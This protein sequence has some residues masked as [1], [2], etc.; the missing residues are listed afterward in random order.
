MQKII[1]DTN[2][3][4]SSLIQ[5]GYSFRI[6]NDLFFEDKFQLCVSDELIKEYYDVLSRPKFAKFQDFFSRAEKL[7]I[8]IE[9]KGIHFIPTIKLNLI[10]DVDDNKILELADKCLADFII[11][12]NTN[13][14]NFTTYKLT[15]IVTPKEY[16]ENYQPS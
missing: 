12:G 3:I 7:L 2:I 11:T 9:T 6:V 4:V 8:D 13:D 5:R 16:W 10:S 1:I 14:F 15:K